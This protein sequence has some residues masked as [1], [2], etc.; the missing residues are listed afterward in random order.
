MGFLGAT[1]KDAITNIVAFVMVILAA[2]QGY[3][4]TLGGQEINWY[5][6]VITIVGAI[7]AYLTGKSGDGTPK[8][9][10]K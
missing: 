3:L 9:L 8:V 7:V 4:G 2:V 6:L 10:P 1:L 5:T